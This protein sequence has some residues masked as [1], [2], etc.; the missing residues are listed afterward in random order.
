MNKKR[1][2]VLGGGYAGVHAVKILLK[3]L[4]GLKDQTEIVLI[5]KNEYHTLMTELHE[6]AG[7][8]VEE[9]S[10]KVSYKRIFAGR[11]VKVIKDEIDEIDF[12]NRKLISA[13]ATYDFDQLLISTGAEAADFGVPGIREHA[14]MLWSLDDAIAIREHVR[15]TVEAASDEKD[16]EKRKELMT[17]VVAGAG[18]TGVEMVGEL[19]EWLPI[20]CDEYEVDHSEITLMNIEGLG[21]ILNVLPDKPRK[22]AEKYMKKKGVDIMVNSLIVEA[23]DDGFKLKSGE[24]IKTKTLIWTCGVRGNRF[25]ER[26]PL[27]DGKVGRKQVNEFM[28]C[29]DHKNVFI[30]GDGCWY[31]ENGSPLPQIVEAAEQTGATAAHAMTANICEELGI[32]YKEPKPFKSRFHGHMVSIGGRYGVS[33]NM[34]MSMS[35]LFAMGIKHVVNVIYLNS[36]AGLNG[37]WTYLK[38]EI[39]DIKNNRSFIGGLAANKVPAY[40]TTFLRIFLG[41][42]WFIEGV[43]KII[44]GWLTDATGSH[45]YWVQ[46]AADAGSAASEEAEQVAEQAVEAVQQFAPPLISEPTALYTWV[47]DTFVAAAPYF[48]QILI[49]LGEVGL[50]LCFIGGLF[51]FPAA[52][53]SI[54]LSIMLIMGAMASKEILWYMAVAVVMMGGAGRSFGLDYWVMPWLKKQWNKTW[55][56][57][58]THLFMDEPQFTRKQ[59]EMRSR[60]MD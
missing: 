35:G 9:E 33:H 39:F 16:P 43:K 51:T 46:A 10:V 37:W 14:L 56:A 7:G 60:I 49:V 40:W 34:N 19:I 50:G 55:L 13:H 5:D 4:K 11:D 15:A 8:R 26:L 31:L 18:F 42:M 52:V 59:K 48:F 41:V 53:A 22:K 32:A 3:T 1:V 6:V 12:D 45:V 36:I 44:E 58:R 30:A 17:F 20:L 27:T 29:P 38:H 21:K 54:G 47:S 2:V 24:Y 25:C 28:G 57:K 23:D